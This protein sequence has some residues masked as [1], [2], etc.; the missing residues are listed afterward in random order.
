[1]SLHK[2]LEYNKGLFM[3]RVLNNEAQEY[4]SNLYTYP[5]SRY[6]NSRKYQLS[7][8]RP[9][10]DIFQTSIAL[11]CA[12]LWNNLPL[13]VRSC[14]SVISF[15]ENF[16]YTLTQLHR[17][18]CDRKMPGGGERERDTERDTHRETERQ[19]QI[20]FRLIAIAVTGHLRPRFYT[21]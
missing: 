3:Y 15:F 19:R 11:P 12:F 2:Q 18:D 7:L 6:S 13:S 21:H 16:V 20:F 1:M 4:I 17:T 9:R 10:L 5:P 8:P 14:H